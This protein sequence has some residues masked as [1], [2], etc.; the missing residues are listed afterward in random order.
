MRTQAPCRALAALLAVFLAPAALAQSAGPV[1]P[2]DLERL[3]FSPGATDSMLVDTGHVLPEG[4]YRLM[5]MVGY[6]RGILLL[7][8]ADGVERD[9]IDYRVASWLA[10]A[11]SPT[12][13][14][15][16]SAKLPVIITQ[17]GSGADQLVGVTEPK[18]FGL[19]T[20]ELGARY[21]LLRRED[22]APVFLGLG[23]DIG[24]PGGT[25]SAF[26][27]QDGWAGFQVAPRVAVGREVGPVSLGAS[28]GVRIRSTEVQPGRDFGSEL[29]QSLVVA[30]RGEGLRGEVALQA[31]ESLVESDV[32]LELLGG[33]RLPVGHG[34][35]AFALAGHGFT[36]IPGTPSLRINAGIAWA[37]TPPSREDPCKG[38][39]THTPEQCPDLDD[40]GDSVA[41]AQDRCPL[42]AGVVENAGCPDG[43]SD[44]DSVVDRLDKC[45]SEPGLPRYQG[46]P[47]PDADGDGIPDDEDACPK[48]AGVA[49]NRGCPVKE[50]KP[51]EAPPPE[52]PREE[53]PP[54]APPAEQTEPPMDHHVLFP[55]G[56]ST[57]EDEEKRQLDAVAA[58][59]K[60]HPRLTV[61]IE[62]HTDNTGPET[63]NR[64][65]SQQRADM[66]RRYL[67]QRGVSGSRLVAKGYGS[68]RPVNGNGTPEEQRLNRRVEFVTKSSGKAPKR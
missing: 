57:L 37:H 38:G 56:Q 52:A 40:D 35:E 45:P 43:D 1:L 7:E 54:A 5:L 24:L 13:R 21:S 23:L 2:M 46:C 32:A 8:G 11:W 61:R 36:D 19:G 3:R 16:L 10:G 15:E 53:P 17:G 60:A 20:P 9:I 59:L 64:T 34:F 27:R 28:V 22:G 41:N 25:A 68:D 42:E 67:I 44:G 63:L 18:S 58:Y 26:G 12:E 47:A 49:A 62:G 14:L 29:E 31:S 30:T 33:L 65:L 4:G 48:E 51:A 50:E 66:V 6:E 39:R 55:V